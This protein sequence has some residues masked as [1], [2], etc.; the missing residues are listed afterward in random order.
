LASLEPEQVFDVSKLITERDWIDAGAEVFRAPISFNGATVLPGDVLD[1]EWYERTGIGLTGEGVLPYLRWVIREKG[2]VELA[3]QSCAMCHTRLMPDGSV[4]EGAQGNFPF[5]T[6]I[7]DAIRYRDVPRPLV[8]RLF[9]LI[10]AAPWN[11]PDSF[12][13][14]SPEQ[15]AA[16]R[17]ASPPGVMP[18]QGTSFQS[19]ARI[20]DL[21]GIQGRKYLDASGLVIHREIGDLMRYAALNQGL[22]VLAR[23]GD[24]VPATGGDR[25]PPPGRG[26]PGGSRGRYSD[27][28]LFALAKF[29]YALE[30]PANPNPV[31]ELARRG[32]EVFNEQACGT[33]HTPPLYTNNQLIPAPGFTPPA[34]HYEKYE[35]F[36]GEVGTDP[37]L[38][39]NTRRGTGYYKVPSLK[40]LWYR[41]P[42]GHSGWVATLEDWFD[43]ARLSSDYVPTGFA[44][45]DGPR[46]V[47]GHPFGLE[48]PDGDKRALIAFLKTL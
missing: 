12:D 45:T 7:A 1:P 32:E 37:E 42:L 14:M 26:P 38:T 13:K 21:I 20:P 22:D 19:P 35:V 17:E 10:S 6:I 4:I 39:M 18:R 23:Y 9:R 43:P 30:P 47:P 2:K 11:P 25:Q 24:F 48:L 8:L 5:E 3:N 31:D 15:L 41:G 46:A 16:I 28:Q 33:C 27:E 34:D 44:G 36:K 29:L 40:G